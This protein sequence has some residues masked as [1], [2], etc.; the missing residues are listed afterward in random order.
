MV[1]QG[2]RVSVRWTEDRIEKLNFL[3]WTDLKDGK[4]IDRALDYVIDNE[5]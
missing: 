1:E 2:D 4:I 3:G 5:R